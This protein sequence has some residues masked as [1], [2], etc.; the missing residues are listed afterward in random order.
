VRRFAATATSGSLRKLLVGSVFRVDT[1]PI[2]LAGPGPSGSADPSRRCRGC[3]PPSPAFSPAFPGSGCPPLHRPA[4]TDRRWSPFT[5]TRYDSASWRSK[6]QIQALDAPNRSCRSRPGRPRSSP[7][8]TAGNGTTT[9]FAALEVATGKV[10]DACYPRHRGVEF[11]K[12]LK[13]VAKAYPRRKLH[14][15]VDNYSAHNH[16]DVKTWL[17]KHPRIV[18]H[19]TPTHSSWMNLVVLLHHHPPSHPPRLVHLR[20]AG[21]RRDP[22]LHRRLE[23][24]LRPLRVDQDRRPDPRQ[25]QPTSDLSNGPLHSFTCRSGASR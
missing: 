20:P 12:F 4:A 24:P 9:L 25:S 13:L 3:F 7:T 10:T 15:V 11:L 1:L 6:S 14:I 2:S 5:S 22:H 21:H 23:R 16:A 19:F 17:A 8:T 18:L